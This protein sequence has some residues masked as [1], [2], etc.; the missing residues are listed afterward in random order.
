MAITSL[1]ALYISGAALGVSIAAGRWLA[2]TGL[3]LVALL[4]FA[5]LGI[6]L[7]HVMNVDSIGPLTGGLI[8]I[9]AFIS[10]T[11]FPLTSGFLYDVGQFTPGF[12]IVQAGH[13][14]LHGHAWTTKGWLVI[15]VW[16]VVLV[17]LA[18]FAYRRDTRRV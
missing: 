18:R 6:A 12:W 1:L 17:A 15:A 2:M 4:P 9:L 8:S 3:I 5:A 13:I 14:A 16:T 11:W 10:G 7:G